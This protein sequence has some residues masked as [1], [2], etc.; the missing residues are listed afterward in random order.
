MEHLKKYP[1][2]IILFAFVILSLFANCRKEN[3]YTGSANLSFGSDT[4][5]FDTVF[6][7]LP[8][9]PYPRS[10]NKQFVIRNPYNDH[11]KTSISLAGGSSSPFRINVDG[12][13]TNDLKDYEI[14]PKDS[15]FV[16]VECTLEPNNQT[17]PALVRDSI[18]VSTNGSIQEVQLAAYGWDAY[19][20]QDSVLE[21]N[22]IWDKTD[23]PYVVV[24]SVAVDNDCQLEI[25][26]GVHIYS[27]G[28][29]QFYILGTL[30]V[31]GTKEQPV[32]FQ[33]DRLDRRYEN[34]PGQWIGL[35]FYR[36]SKNNEINFA[37][38]KNAIIGVR[39]DSLSV[40]SN[41]KLT[42]RNSIIQ[43]CSNIGLLGITADVAVDNSIIHNCGSYTF[44]GY[45]GGNYN[46]RNNTFVNY[47][48]G[49]SRNDPHFVFNNI[50]LDQN[51]NFVRDYNISYNVQNCIIYGSNEDEIQFDISSANPPSSA[52][53]QANII[54]TKNT[55]LNFNG[56]LLNVGHTSSPFFKDVIF[57]DYFNYNFELDSLSPAIDNGVILSPA[58]NTDFENNPRDGTPDIGA[59][60][61]KH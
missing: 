60:E 36:F 44:L 57:E 19:Y 32:V 27:S 23:K 40:N 3:F 9:S 25:K 29:S 59:Y 14:R 56:N 58:L 31:N 46:L 30:K 24:N 53:I 13:P 41:Q 33:A 8:G 43:N 38:I 34:T 49:F 51:D 48:I 6:T 55:D 52:M 5:Y 4:I 10:I 20:F 21:C 35:H 45:F 47:N 54:R 2:A 39:V 16:F 61:D 37:E 28:N 1:I 15:I 17:Q 12:I 11:I 7:R 42:M 50:Q 22:A 18:I 26:P